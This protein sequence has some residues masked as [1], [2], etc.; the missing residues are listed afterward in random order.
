[1]AD[2]VNLPL[3]G[4]G[5]TTATVAAEDISGVHYQ[6]IK[7]IDAAAGSTAAA[8]LYSSAVDATLSSAGSTRIIGMVEGVPFSSANI[9]RSTLNSSA[10]GQL[11][12]A[13]PARNYVAITNMATAVTLFVGLSGSS[14][15]TA[16]ANA[17]FVIPPL[18]TYTLGGQLGNLPRYTGPIRCRLNSTTIAGPVIGVEFA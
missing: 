1:M 13:N 2:N 6:R 14:V 18:T 10:E 9:T 8:T 17:H 3:T 16:G 4:S 7:L 5:G 11:F 15:S 12:A